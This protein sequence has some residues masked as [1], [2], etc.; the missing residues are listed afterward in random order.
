MGWGRYGR[1][2]DNTVVGNWTVATA[3]DLEHGMNGVVFVLCSAES[4]SDQGIES[5]LDPGKCIEWPAP[6]DLQRSFL[7]QVP[8]MQDGMLPFTWLCAG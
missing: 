5:L 3:V 7:V 8:M 1:V 2:R 4:R 6:R